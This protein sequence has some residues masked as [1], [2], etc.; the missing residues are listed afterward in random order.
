M[1][2]QKQRKAVASRGRPSRVFHRSHR[3][4]YLGEDGCSI[5]FDKFLLARFF[6]N[7]V[8]FLDRLQYRGAHFVAH[9]SLVSQATFNSSIGFPFHSRSSLSWVCLT[10]WCQMVDNGRLPCFRKLG[11]ILPSALPSKSILL[12]TIHSIDSTLFYSNPYRIFIVL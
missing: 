2:W 8:H 12:M 5:D 11:M 7:P 6:R 9:G 10:S 4:S 3:H 1:A